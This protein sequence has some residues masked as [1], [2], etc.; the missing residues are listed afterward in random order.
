[1]FSKQGRN[2]TGF[3]LIELVIF[4]VIVSVALTGVLTVLNITTKSSADPIIRKQA[5]AIAE[6]LLEEVMLQPF[7]YC[8]PDD[9]TAATATSAAINTTGCTTTVE[10][11]GPDVNPDG[12]TETRTSATDPFDNVNDYN[13]LST[14]TN[15]A[16]GGAARYI[17]NI[18]VTAAPL[19]TITVASGDA[20][21]VSVSVNSG[22][23]NIVL[24]GYRTRYS[25]NTLP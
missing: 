19:N 17:A 5:L 2:Q 11:I 12:T 16:G 8:D 7:T 23:E 14:T 4:I 6:A 15:V 21:L 13:G 3:T 25:P 10:A 24:E 18:T 1:M 9:A 22:S 20:L